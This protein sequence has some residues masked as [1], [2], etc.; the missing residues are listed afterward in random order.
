MA[1]KFTHLDT[2][3]VETT[4]SFFSD[5]FI[6][7]RMQSGNPSNERF[8]PIFEDERDGEWNEEN[9]KEIKENQLKYDEDVNQYITLT[10]S[11]LVKPQS[12]ALVSKYLVSMELDAGQLA[13]QAEERSKEFIVY[14]VNADYLLLNLGLFNHDSNILGNAYVDK[15]SSYYFSAASS[16]KRVF[17]GRSALTDV[18]EK[19]SKQFRKYV[20]I[21]RFMKNSDDN[22]LSFHFRI[23]VPKMETLERTL[24]IETQKRKGLDLQ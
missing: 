20:E 3:K 22:Y 1:E 19:L 12:L 15:G 23:P 2:G 24:T 10:L 11:D 18:F 9:W 13:L 17:G 5:R 8:D 7:A 16:L 6:R 4:E 21:L 14:R